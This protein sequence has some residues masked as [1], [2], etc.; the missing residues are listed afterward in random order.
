MC[1]PVVIEDRYDT[2]TQ[3]IV[4]AFVAG[5][6]NALKAERPMHC[7]TDEYA[8]RHAK[9]VAASKLGVVA[10]STSGD[11]EAGDYDEQPNILFKTGRLPPPFE[12]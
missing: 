2:Q 6:G 9:N 5:K 3:F 12:E 11:E 4:Q 1:G 8:V 10:Y 7:K